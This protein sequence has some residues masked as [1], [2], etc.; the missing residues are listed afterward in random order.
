VGKTRKE[1]K[2][3]VNIKVTTKSTNHLQSHP[4]PKRILGDPQP[5]REGPRSNEQIQRVNLGRRLGRASHLRR[6]FVTTENVT[7]DVNVVPTGPAATCFLPTMDRI[8][9]S[10]L[11]NPST[12]V[13]LPTIQGVLAHHLATISPVPT[14]LAATAI[15]SPFFLAQP[16]THLK[17]QTFST[18]FRHA[19]HL[20]YRA[21]IDAT[22]TRS[23][24]RTMLGRSRESVLAQWVT[25]VLKGVQGGHPILRLAACGGLISG[26]KDVKIGEKPEKEGGIDVGSARFAVED[27]IVLSLAEVMDKYS[28]TSASGSESPQNGV[29]ERENEFQPAGRLEGMSPS[30]F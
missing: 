4:H 22:K 23:K 13:P 19:T 1:G 7:H 25:D 16:F 17:L 12:T 20:K 24:M 30:W 15:S 8:L 18:T 29:E 11:H 9:L 10:H 14:P 27:E 26:V 2:Q 6:G 3:V 21:I 5:F 28:S